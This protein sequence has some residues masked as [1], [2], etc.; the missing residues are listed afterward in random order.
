MQA[1]EAVSRVKV[2]NPRTSVF[3]FYFG[4]ALKRSSLDETN[5]DFSL[6]N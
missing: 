4:V 3:P 5:A 1:Q 6:E 2:Q